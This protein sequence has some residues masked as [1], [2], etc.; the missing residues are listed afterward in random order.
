MIELQLKDT[1]A[2]ETL[3]LP[4]PPLSITDSNKDVKV[5]TL[6][7]SLHVYIFPNADKRVWVQ[8]WP[9]MSVADY[10]VVR[11]FWTRQRASNVFPELSITGLVSGDIVDVPVF[12][13]MSEKN[14]IDN[15][16]T[17]QDVRVTFTEG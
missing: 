16:E 12:I 7:N 14:I 9:Y 17:I 3:Q 11:G 15:C 8:S 2:T 4:S 10:L 5:N 1:T 6:D 13:E